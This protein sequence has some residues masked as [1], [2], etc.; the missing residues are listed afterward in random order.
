MDRITAEA[1]G[2][3]IEFL[4]TPQICT[5]ATEGAVGT[6]IGECKTTLELSTQVSEKVLVR[7]V[8]IWITKE[9]MPQLLL[10]NDLLRVLGI[11]VM[12]AVNALNGEY[13]YDAP[14]ETYPYPG[15]EEPETILQALKKK[16]D[17]AV[18]NGLPGGD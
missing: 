12:G 9:K 15:G 10:G 11:D 3:D 5:L 16:I 4:D 17:D 13:D 18:V 2:I 7:N 6:I 1:A 14:V 8:P